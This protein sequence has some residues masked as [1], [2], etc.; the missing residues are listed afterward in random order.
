MGR[1]ETVRGMGESSTHQEA[2]LF[3]FFS[4]H[5]SSYKFQV[6]NWTCVRYMCVWMGV[7]IGGGCVG[8]SL[9]SGSSD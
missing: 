1:G 6:F 3:S 2:M 4:F 8:D 5:I 7:F 9:G